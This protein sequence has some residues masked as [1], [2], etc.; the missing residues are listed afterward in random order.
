MASH[1]VRS[2]SSICNCPIRCCNR[3]MVDC[4]GGCC[5]LLLWVDHT[6]EWEAIN[7]SMAAVDV[8]DDDGTTAA[9]V[10]GDDTGGGDTIV[11]TRF[12]CGGCSSTTAG[13]GC[14]F[15]ILDGTWMVVTR[16]LLVT[17]VS[18]EEGVLGITGV[19][20]TTLE[21]SVASSFWVV[22]V[23]F[24]LVSVAAFVASSVVL[25]LVLVVLVLVVV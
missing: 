25:V 16:L 22:T 2:C 8:V 4:G 13:A 9:V 20:F 14:L 21:S 12:P 19:S 23:E 11:T 18:S 17:L 7:D 3:S 1:L 5:W 15:F 24:P 10:A 6:E